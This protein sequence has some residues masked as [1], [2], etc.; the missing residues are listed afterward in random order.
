[1]D[2]NFFQTIYLIRHAES[3]MAGCYCGSID[4]PLSKKGE[5][6]AK[7]VG[8]FFKT[9]P[10]EVC[11]FSDL[12]RTSQTCQEIKEHKNGSTLFIKTPALREISFGAWEGHTFQEIS[13]EWPKLYKNWIQSPQTTQIPKGEPFPK[14]E[15]RIK[16]FSKILQKNS[17]KEIAI[18]AHGGTLALLTILL[19]KKSMKEFW[20]WA[21]ECASI[22][23]LEKNLKDKNNK[24][25]W[26]K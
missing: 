23:I 25:K 9:I 22:T 13:K 5:R 2:P 15:K 8:E 12:K 18:V 16:I 26:A 21:P 7:K 4:A 20:K 19:L 14:F 17:S 1:M 3:A 24:F 10:L 6:Q 11:Y